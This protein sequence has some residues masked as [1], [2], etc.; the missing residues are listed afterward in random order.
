M[1]MVWPAGE[2]IERS[3]PHK[4]RMRSAATWP[5]WRPGMRHYTQPRPWGLLIPR[6]GGV[7]RKDGPK[8][9]EV[10]QV[11]EMCVR[12]KQGRRDWTCF[13][14]HA[15]SYASTLPTLPPTSWLLRDEGGAKS[16]REDPSTQ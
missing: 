10:I 13:F 1:V 15:L 6:G 12:E 3:A 7:L 8:G 9:K 2:T 4:I 14:C 5:G 11:G 16:E